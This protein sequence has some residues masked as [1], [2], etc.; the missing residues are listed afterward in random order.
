M[1]VQMQDA[2]TNRAASDQR[3]SGGVPDAGVANVQRLTL[4]NYHLRQQPTPLRTSPTS[5]PAHL[6]IDAYVHRSRTGPCFVCAILEGARATC[7]TASTRIRTLRLHP[8]RHDRHDRAYDEPRRVG[9]YDRVWDAGRRQVDRHVRPPRPVRLV[10]LTPGIDVCRR[11]NATRDP[12]ERF[13]FDGYERLE[14]DMK[15]EFGD[16]AWWFDTAAL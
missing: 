11:R 10:I 13:E 5:T 3:L 1:H 4:D 16:C 15:R 14:A 6:G 7:T 12:Q 8:S 9:L 2:S